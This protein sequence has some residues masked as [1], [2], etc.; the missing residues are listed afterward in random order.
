MASTSI[1]ERIVSGTALLAMLLCLSHAAA[2]LTYT[3][4]NPKAKGGIV[5]VIKTDQKLQAVIAVEPYT[6]K[7]YKGAVQA[8]GRTFRFAG[9]E[10]GEY[11]LLIKTTGH[12]YEGLTLDV[13]NEDDD[14]AV[15]RLTA[16]QLQAV[17]DDTAKYWFKTEDYFNVKKIIRFES[18]G[19]RAR[20]FVMQVRTKQ[21][22]DPAGTPIDAHIRRFDFV[23]MV[24][25]KK[26][27]QVLKSRHLLRQEVPRKS[28]DIK[29]KTTYSPALGQFLVG[30]K[31]KDLGEI[32][33]K[34]L[35]KLKAPRYASKSN[36][37]S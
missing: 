1:H 11:D 36:K 30:E 32:D 31:V 2:D 9:L 21:V 24:K 27:W 20:M 29:L 5:G 33:L 15:S 22:V 26:V 8:D 3:K 6:F 28:K 12:L 25:T 37:A 34:K 14:P 4:P 16:K 17:C 13:P 10:P 19:K 35:P 23:D 18:D 7:F